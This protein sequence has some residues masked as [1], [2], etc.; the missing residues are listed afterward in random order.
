MSNTS[1]TPRTQKARVLYQKK[2]WESRALNSVQTVDIEFARKLELENIEL[3]KD[4]ER[5]EWIIKKYNKYTRENIDKEISSEKQNSF[6]DY[7]S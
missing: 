5:L 4:K 7:N 3:L 1:E 6:S 2:I